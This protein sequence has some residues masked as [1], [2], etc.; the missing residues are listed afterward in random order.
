M[1]VA[2]GGVSYAATNISKN[3]VGT[4]QLKKNAVNSAK[5]KNKSL[6][7]V[8]FKPGQL[9]QGEQGERG[10]QGPQGIQGPA[11]QDGAPGI[12][13]YQQSKISTTAV[14]QTSD[15]ATADCLSGQVVLGG[16]AR[17]TGGNSTVVIRE[18]YPLDNDSFYAETYATS[19]S[20]VHGIEVT[21]ICATLSP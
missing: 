9:P 8:D 18:A 13:G 15:S 3:S 21:A 12:S 11:G 14:L 7:A 4:K 10:M 2:L 6:K 17:V 5:V 1:F 16:G 19:G 20:V